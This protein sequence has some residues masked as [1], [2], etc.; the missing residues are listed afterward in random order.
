MAWSTCSSSPERDPGSPPPECWASARRT[1][2]EYGVS[3]AWWSSSGAESAR[4]SSARIA[5]SVSSSAHTVMSWAMGPRPPRPA[6]M[7]RK[8]VSS[9]GAASTVAAQRSSRPAVS[10]A[11]STMIE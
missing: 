6:L 9:R 8:L 7:C 10:E 4:L 11:S 5:A 2:P 1:I 3:T